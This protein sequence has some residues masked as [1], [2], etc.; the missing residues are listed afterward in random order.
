MGHA[1]ERMRGWATEGG[2]RALW[3]VVVGAALLLGGCGG[4]TPAKPTI[5]VGVVDAERVLADSVPGQKARDSLGT[6]MK[7]R[8]QLIEL[9]EKELRRLEED[10]TKQ[11]SVLSANAKKEREEQFRRRVMEYQQK[12]GEL[13]RE[14]Q[15]KQKEVFEAFRER[16]ERASAKVAEQMGLLMVLEKG[17]ATTTI[18]SDASLDITA[19]VI[20][21]LNK[22]GP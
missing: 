10:L 1:A 21:E 6:F 3:G 22:E 19:K 7:T 18:Y 8:Q 20:E 14:V 9:E 12:A 17:K 15:E 5:Q 4:S 16:V 11:A 13:N 2:R